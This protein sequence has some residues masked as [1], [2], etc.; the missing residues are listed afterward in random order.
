M[1]ISLILPYWD[2]QQAANEALSLLE[3]TYKD[4]DLEVVIVDDGN[5]IPFL[6]NTQ[7]LKVTVVKLPEKDIPKCPVTAWNEGVYAASGDIIVLS[8]IEILHTKPVLEQMAQAVKDIGPKGYV[9]ASAWCP[10]SCE[11]HCHSSIKTPRNPWGTGIAFCAAMHKSLFLEAGGFDEDYREGAGY[12][13]NDFINRLL[14]ARARFLIRDDLVVIHPKTNATISWGEERFKRNEDLYYNK[15]PNELTKPEVN[16]V[17]LNSGN[18]CNRGTDYVNNLFYMVSR[19]LSSNVKTNFYCLTDNPSG[20]DERIKTLHLPSNLSGWWGKLYLFK[21]GLFKENDRIIYL[22]LDTLVVSNIDDIVAYDG[23]FAILRDFLIP[24]QEAPGIM[25]WR[26]GVGYP[27]WDEWV[28]Q[29]CPTN[30]MGDLWWFNKIKGK[31]DTVDILQDIYPNDFVSYKLSATLAPPIGCSFVCF[32][33]IPRPHEV[34]GWVENVW[35]KDGFTT[36][37]MEVENNISHEK[38]VRNIY[39]SSI[40][41][42]DWLKLEEQTHKEVVIVGGGPSLKKDIDKI[43]AHKEDGAYIMALNGAG[44]FLEKND[45]IPDC[46]VVIDARD[47]NLRFV[48]ESNASKYFLASQCDPS[49]FDAVGDK[50][51]LFHID[52]P[53]LGYYVPGDKEIQAV[54]GGITVGL[55]SMSLAYT[56]GYRKMHLY[57]Y[58]SSYDEDFHH[59]YNQTENDEEPLVEAVVNGKS[60]T[61]APWMVVQTN[62]FQDLTK[63]L[64]ELKCEI[65]VHG[66]GLLPTVAWAMAHSS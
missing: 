55:L 66:Y 28:S 25:M 17:C 59:A 16:F 5:K 2:R 43:K 36:S 61:C 57:G 44:L 46:V 60:F 7:K 45:I 31:M 47:C 20:L 29:G 24:S 52:I 12:E 15:W 65:Y 48:K 62:Q 23:D 42:L 33:G 54:G 64:I 1:K 10:E 50:A 34:E 38:I 40:R 27:I 53:N 9:L 6:N 21:S 58:D 8:C 63:Q 13:D 18:Y 19:N 51:T 30:P 35:K 39:S 4:L 37:E 56:L 41:D 11:W 26:A 32:H 49:L 3:D 14:K 22:D